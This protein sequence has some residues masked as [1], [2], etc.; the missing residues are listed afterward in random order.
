MIFLEFYI[1]EEVQV[2]YHA[3]NIISLYNILIGY[4]KFQ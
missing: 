2:M 1:N 3:T 4:K